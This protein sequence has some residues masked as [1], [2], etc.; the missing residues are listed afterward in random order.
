MGG[1]CR[2][3]S[4]LGRGLGAECSSTRCVPMRFYM[5]THTLV[6]AHTR[7][8][9]RA[10]FLQSVPQSV[11]VPPYDYAPVIAGQ[12]TMALEILDQVGRAAWLLARRGVSAEG[13]ER[14]R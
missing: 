5:D 4:L 2:Y 8:H 3:C 9:A 11:L 12:G 7:T 14:M 1:C 6:L 10:L 13:W